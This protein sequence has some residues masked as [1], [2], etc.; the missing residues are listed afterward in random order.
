MHANTCA[1]THTHT[2]NFPDDVIT[3]LEFKGHI[4]ANSSSYAV[5]QGV[6]V[7]EGGVVSAH[8]DS[9]KQGQAVTLT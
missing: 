3:F 5:V 8:S 1:H 9:R 2:D 6:H 7:N 4:I